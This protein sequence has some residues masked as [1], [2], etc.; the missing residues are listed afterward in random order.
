MTGPLASAEAGTTVLDVIA[1]DRLLPVVVLDD[2]EVAP[3]LGAALV[4]GGLRSVEVTLR[5]P[6]AVAAIHALADHTA[7]VVGAGTVTSADQVDQ[8]V[9]AGARF[10]VCPGFSAAV[11]RRCQK[12]GVPV[13]PGVATPTEIQMALDAGLSVLK[14]F[15]A[16]RLGGLPM[17]EALAAPY[18]GLRFVPTGGITTAN[19]RGYLDHPSVLAVGGTWMVAA[20]L[21]TAGRWD[22][23]T[24]LTAAALAA[25]REGDR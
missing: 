9:D 6:A 1:G 22:D 19:L 8:V 23:V 3:R 12:H 21:L 2:A 14:F 15:P 13:I 16:E 10:V 25:A 4:A 17:L 24:T 5:T 11:V 18:P 7:L 20:G